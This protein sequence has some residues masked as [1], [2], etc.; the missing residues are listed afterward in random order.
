[1]TEHRQSPNYIN[2]YI[3]HWI[4]GSRWLKNWGGKKIIHCQYNSSEFLLKERKCVFKLQ[5]FSSKLF[6]LLVYLFT[7]NNRGSTTAR[8]RNEWKFD[9]VETNLY[10]Y[11]LNLKAY[12]CVGESQ[13]EY[14]RY[15][16]LWNDKA[17]TYWNW[18]E[19]R[20][21]HLMTTHGVNEDHPIWDTTQEKGYSGTDDR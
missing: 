10:K 16:H 21:N 1:M 11:K 18:S 12:V 20:K 7:I 13:I 5:K 3:T 17:S 8:D 15:K 2:I 4:S 19:R 14:C 6:E 9:V